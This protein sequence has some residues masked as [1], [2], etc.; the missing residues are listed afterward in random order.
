MTVSSREGFSPSAPLEAEMSLEPDWRLDPMADPQDAR[1]TR[2]VLLVWVVVFCLPRSA[3]ATTL[4]VP[5]DHGTIQAALSAAASGDTVV[6][7]PGTYAGPENRDLSFAGKNLVVLGSGPDVTI[8]D[9]AGSPS[10]PHR[11]FDFRDGE[12]PSAVLDGLTIRNGYSVNWS[13]GINCRGSSPTVRN[14]VIEDCTAATF[15]GGMGIWFGSAPRL[16]ACSFL[17]N[18]AATVGG[19][20]GVTGAAVTL[21]GCEL[22]SNEAVQSGGGGIDVA[23]GE[24]AIANCE[25]EA[26]RAG[27]SGGGIR[28]FSHHA[29][30]SRSR[31]VGNSATLTGG[32]ITGLFATV[33]IDE[34]LITGNTSGDGAGLWAGSNSVWRIQSSTVA[35]NNA[36]RNGGGLFVLGNGLFVETTIFRGSCAVEGA[37]VYVG[38]NTSGPATVPF[39]CCALDTSQVGGPGVIDYTDGYVLSLDPRFCTPVPCE[40]APTIGGDLALADDSPCLPANNACGVLIGALQEGCAAASLPDAVASPL[41]PHAYPSPLRSFDT[42]RLRLAEGDRRADLHDVAGRRVAAVWNGQGHSVTT[43]DVVSW[44]LA[45]LPAGTYYLRVI[46][47]SGSRTAKIVV[48]Q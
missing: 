13:G 6:V 11:G 46:G 18:S 35:G 9:C 16:V 23:N 24:V 28:V 20:L 5:T 15:G 33:V 31:I 1:V 7:L 37:E 40:A 3:A 19:G 41:E 26:N 43:G 14:C 17:R 39:S 45:L 25:I 21:D 48:T 36:S 38:E 34:V 8:I 44:R 22:R 4:T 2:L 29:E 10:E 12:G 42:L 27:G 47:K 32:A 30:I